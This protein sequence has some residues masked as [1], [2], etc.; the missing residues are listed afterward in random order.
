MSTRGRRSYHATHVSEIEPLASDLV[1]GEWRPVRY[2]FG[3][4]AFGCNAYRAR[5]A[6]ELIIEDHVEGEDG[7]EELYVVLEGL[8]RFTLDGEEVEAG[9]GTLVFC[10]PAAQRKA[11]AA[12]PG[13][14]VLA[15]GGAP[16]RAFQVSRWES[17][18]TP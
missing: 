6:G 2:H 12:E 14:T 8:A 7:D 15:V 3:I 5:A 13:T 17:S 9:A 16:G 10:T 11:V 18:R 1:E 4:S